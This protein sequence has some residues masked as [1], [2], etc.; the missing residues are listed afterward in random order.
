MS[1]RVTKEILDRQV[2]WLNTITGGTY[3]LGYAYGGVRIEA[4]AGGRDVSPRGSKRAISTMLGVMIRTVLDLQQRENFRA[5][6]VPAHEHAAKTACEEY[7]E[8]REQYCCV[9]SESM[10]EKGDYKP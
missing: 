9:R 2:E 1:N 10:L 6:T 5:G 3:C 7:V 4:E 8:S